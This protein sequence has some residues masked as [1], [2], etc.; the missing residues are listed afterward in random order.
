MSRIEALFARKNPVFIGFTVAGDPDGERSFGVAATMVDAGVDLLEIAVPYSDPVADGPVIERA[1]V[2][3]LRAGTTL[4]D[5]FA[6]VRRV[7]KHA[8]DLPIVLFTY[9]NVVHRRGPE[10]FF[11]EAAADADGVLIVDLPVEESDEV[12]PHAVRYGID[13]IALIAPT[14]SPER[15]HAILREASG[16]VYLISLEGVTGERDRLPPGIACLVGAVREKTNLPLAVGFGVS[17]P[18]HVRIVVEAGANGVI[19]GS[20][21]VRIIEEHSSDEAAMDEA[22]ATAIRSLRGGLVPDPEPDIPRHK[23]VEG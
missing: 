17:C 23:R 15:Q 22:L 8:P 10:R 9:Y 2:R 18:E 12:A 16:F 5:V 14:T 21:L 3:A 13:R 7:R 11:S 20:A 19:V 1:H 6:L 4:D